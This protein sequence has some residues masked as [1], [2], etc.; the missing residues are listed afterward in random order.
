MRYRKLWIKMM[1]RKWER[2]QS[3]WPSQSIDPL[4]NRTRILAGLFLSPPVT[5]WSAMHPRML[6]FSIWFVPIAFTKWWENVIWWREI[7]IIFS[8][9]ISVQSLWEILIAPLQWLLTSKSQVWRWISQ[10]KSTKIPPKLFW[11]VKDIPNTNGME[12]S[13]DKFFSLVHPSSSLIKN[14]V[15]VCTFSK[16]IPP[17]NKLH[18]KANKKI[19]TQDAQYIFATLT[20]S[21]YTITDITFT[22]YTR[23]VDSREGGKPEYP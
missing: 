21:P 19:S 7:V 20:T 5:S 15:W 10:T 14:H 8:V 22:H 17:S 13:F 1:W 11:V 6:D 2:V 23:C 16:S 3:H 4:K 12:D 9:Y 18:I